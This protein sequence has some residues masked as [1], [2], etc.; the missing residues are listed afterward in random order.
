M[1]FFVLAGIAVFF[2]LI[3]IFYKNICNNKIKTLTEIALRTPIYIHPITKTILED[4]ARD[5][6]ITP[7]YLWGIGKIICTIF[8]YVSICAFLCSIYFASVS[9]LN[10]LKSLLFQPVV[11]TFVLFTFVLF[12]PCI[13]S[14]LLFPW[15]KSPSLP[16][17]R[18]RRRYCSLCR[19]PFN[20]YPVKVEDFLTDVE[21]AAKQNGSI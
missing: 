3:V 8:L 20:C 9:W 19:S 15:D 4:T 5:K 17:K 6:M 16:L 21:K 10:S 11:I 2:L 13:L 7:D 14:S 12:G 1:V 18:S